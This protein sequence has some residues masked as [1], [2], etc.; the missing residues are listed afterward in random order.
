MRRLFFFGLLMSL[1]TL[2]N[3]AQGLLP[4]T[5]QQYLNERNYSERYKAS[6]KADGICS[7][8][9]SP[10]EVD[11]IEVIDAFIAYDN[12]LTISRLQAAGVIINSLFD[13]F[14]TAQIPVD[15]LTQVSRMPGV[16]DVEISRRLELCTDSTMRVTH[17]D[18]LINEEL[19]GAY[20]PFDGR[21]VIVGV[22]DLG[23]DFQHRA[24]R[25]ND[26]P[27]KTR[28]VRVYNTKDKTGHKAMYERNILL[29]GS[30]FMGDEIYALTTDNGTNTHGTHTASIAAGSHVNGYGGMAP[31]TDIVLCAVSVL[32]GGMSAVEVAN[33]VRY[34]DSY[35]D[36]V[37]QPCV[38][39]LSVST[40][41]GQHDGLDYL[42]RVVKGIMGPGR[43]FV[44]SAGNNAGG[45]FYAHREANSSSPI[46]LMF[47][48]KNSLGGDSTYYYK[49]VNADV[50]VRKQSTNL[51]Y[52]F[53]V[54]D[55]NT[56]H[57]VWESEI[58]TGKAKITSNDLGDYYDYYSSVDT[59]GYIDAENIFASDGKKY[60][61]SIVIRNLISKKYLL[62]NGVKKSRYAIGV[63]LYPRREATSEF[64]A[65]ICNS[66]ARFGVYHGNVTNM[67][68]TVVNNFYA[69]PSDS[70]CIGSYAVGDSTI[71]AGAFSARNSYYSLTQRK[72][73]TDNS[74]V[75][76]DIA[77]FSSY[78]V[79]GAGPTGK[80]LPDI[81]APGTLVVA[82]ANRYSYLANS[83]NT[84][85][86]Y[87]NSYWGVMSGTS[88]A[89]PTV[90]GI[91]ALWLQVN[92]R[93]CVSQVKEIIANTAIRDRYTSGEHRDQFGPNG[94][95]NALEGML[96]VLKSLK[97]LKGD[98]NNDGNL[99][100]MDVTALINYLLDDGESINLPAAD[101]NSDGEIN[102]TDLTALIHLLLNRL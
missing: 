64:D 24:F 32:D 76:G 19:F 74:I 60:H 5:V 81:C 40:P 8:F 31:G 85:M 88:M 73:V 21:G 89:A 66:N 63:T 37:G 16:T 65:W 62:V 49:G 14:A 7:Q 100:I 91:I 96:V 59:T 34:I 102:I 42:S 12:E 43:I 18:E 71:S 25:S 67:D 38:I 80:A 39:S 22:I 47:K 75:I 27:T 28:I 53:H 13:G 72:T 69:S 77:S 48:C 45:K 70:C 11:G 44:V 4:V 55:L 33:C 92:P 46:N 35:A 90:A 29:P 23:F 3:Y 10:K 2:S 99:N 51:Y 84:V 95:I 6:L 93:L 79:L 41:N 50:W 17:V 94:K 15:R 82:A 30:V 57:I 26:D 87:D 97:P 20:G 54:L 1:M 86:M 56:G 83:T 101:V 52:K 68:G 9:V 36:S 98:V 78:E 58:F 61:L